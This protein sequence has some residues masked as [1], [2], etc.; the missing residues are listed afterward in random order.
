MFENYEWKQSKITPRGNTYYFYPTNE[1]EFKRE[2]ADNGGMIVNVY[3]NSEL[4]HSH[5]TKKWRKGMGKTCLYLF[6][7][8]EY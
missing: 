6:K 7:K 3:K 1:A 8:Y 4:I 2:V 5:K